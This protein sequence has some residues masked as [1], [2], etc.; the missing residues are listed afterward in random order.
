MEEVDFQDVYKGKFWND[1]E[2]IEL[3]SSQV[4]LVVENGEM[5]YQIDRKKQEILEQISKNK[6]N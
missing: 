5:Y 1:G 3:W 4:G 2:V 6:I